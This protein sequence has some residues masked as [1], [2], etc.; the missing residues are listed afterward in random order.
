M[1]VTVTQE[2]DLRAEVRWTR[3][4]DRH[5]HLARTVASGE[6]AH[7]LK[8][9]ADEYGAGYDPQ[10]PADDALAAAAD[11]TRLARLLEA[12]G[13]DARISSN[14]PLGAGGRRPTQACVVDREDAMLGKPDPEEC[15]ESCPARDH[16]HCWGCGAR[17]RDP[18][19]PYG[20]CAQCLRQESQPYE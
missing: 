6:L 18:N 19:P 15:P 7:A 4:D 5:G 2:T 1:A 8:A 20:L 17:T 3:L 12:V 16:G 9:L 14:R 11:T 13:G 10:G